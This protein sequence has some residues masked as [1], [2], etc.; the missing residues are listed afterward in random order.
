M[1]STNDGKSTQEIQASILHGQLSYLYDDEARCR[2]EE[3]KRR[4]IEQQTQLE[5]RLKE[6]YSH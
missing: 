5:E 6:I 4:I 3:E 2:D 1:T